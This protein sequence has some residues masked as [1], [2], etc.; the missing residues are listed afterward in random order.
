MPEWNLYVKLTDEDREVIKRLE[1][2]YGANMNRSDIVREALRRMLD[3][4]PSF[5]RVIEPDT[6][7]VAALL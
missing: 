2:M 1:R 7:P 4:K 5:T 3:Q 6:Q